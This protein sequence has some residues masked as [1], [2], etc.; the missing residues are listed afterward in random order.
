MNNLF[1]G[2]NHN[3]FNPDCYLKTASGSVLAFTK[4]LEAI[5]AG[6]GIVMLVF[7]SE[8]I[9]GTI[10]EISLLINQYFHF[11][12]PEKIAD[13]L[14]NLVRYPMLLPVI[15]LLLIILD[16]IGVLMMRYSRS[17]EGLVQIIHTVYWLSLVIE[18]IALIIGMLR[19]VLGLDDLSQA[20]S[21]NQSVYTS[22]GSMGIFVWIWFLAALIG[23][24]FYY[25][26]HHDICT[27][28]KAVYQER[29]SGKPVSVQKNHLAGRSGWFAWGSG[30][31]FVLSAILVIYPLLTKTNLISD[32]KIREMTDIPAMVLLIINMLISLISFAKY[33]SLRICVRNFQ[34]VHKG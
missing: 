7:V 9:S 34:K 5:A 17:G 32:E 18:I 21:G 22:L 1:G 24:L 23:L 19:F 8:A 2:G 6:I 16:G 28:L 33:L 14:S 25:N 20:M 12:F 4:M 27:V 31:Y 10:R 29:V 15:I 13:T 26:Y 30:C 3:R 11:V